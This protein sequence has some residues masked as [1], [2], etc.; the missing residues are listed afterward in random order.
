MGKS[1]MPHQ[2]YF[3][4]PE[5]VEGNVAEARYRDRTRFIRQVICGHTIANLALIVATTYCPTVITLSQGVLAFLLSLFLLTIQRRCCDKGLVGNG[6]SLLILLPSLF[7]L[8][9]V[10]RHLLAIGVPLIALVPAIISVAIYA[11][12]CGNDFSYVGKFVL[13]SLSTAISLIVMVAQGF[14]SVSS[15]LTGF[16]IVVLYLFFLAYDLS[17][18]VKR[19]RMGEVPSAVADLFRDQLNFITYSVRVYIHWR[20]FRFI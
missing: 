2:P 8:S 6:I 10:F 15:A 14:V 9:Q 13:C 1:K 18:L 7:F 17:M 3:P 16:L 11:L 12:L 4:E 5:T 20:K 19:R